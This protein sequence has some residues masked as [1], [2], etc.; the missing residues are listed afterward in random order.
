[1]KIIKVTLPCLSLL[2]LFACNDEVADGQC[3]HRSDFAKAK[4]RSMNKLHSKINNCTQQIN[5][6]MERLADNMTYKLDDVVQELEYIKTAKNINTTYN[7]ITKKHHC[8]FLSILSRLSFLGFSIATVVEISKGAILTPTSTFVVGI[9]GMIISFAV[10]MG[11][12]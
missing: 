3:T 11:C 2:L 8:G 5:T 10:M 6:N 9:M 12:L 1:M 4:A 7:N